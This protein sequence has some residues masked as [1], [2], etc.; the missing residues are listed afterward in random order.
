MLKLMG[1][2][3]IWMKFSKIMTILSAAAL[4]FTVTATTP[5][6]SDAQVSGRDSNTCDITGTVT[7]TRLVERSPFGDNTPSTLSV[8]ETHIQVSIHKR[9]PHRTDAPAESP[10]NKALEKNEMRTYKLCSNTK[11]QKGDRIRGTEGGA[12]GS[13]K[14]MRCLFDIR[15][16][17]PKPAP[18]PAPAPE[19]AQPN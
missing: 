11:P 8:F 14:I 18:A 3:R 19:A 9:R 6:H 17:R 10:C 4:S 1:V 13:T 5:R 12:T 15:T 7:D 16:I 2:G